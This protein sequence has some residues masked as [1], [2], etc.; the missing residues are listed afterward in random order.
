MTHVL[1]L[2]GAGGSAGFWAPAAGLLPQ[3]WT[4][5]LFSWPGLG[6]EAHHPA[7]RG[8]DDLTAL[9]TARMDGPVHLVAQSMGG[10]VAVKAALARP[11]MVRSLALTGTSGGLDVAALGG[12]DWRDGYRREYPNAAGWIMEAREDL[13]GRIPEIGAPALLLWGD[14]DTIS[15]VAVGERLA[16]L[17]PRATL[18]VIA[19]GDHGFPAA[20]AARIAPL[21]RDHIDAAERLSRA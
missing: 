20:H 6:D 18:R 11:E 14:A 3:G 16:S 8:L 4:R 7:V 17:L 1:F 2:P 10:M 5:H 21:I 12:A 15:P 9:V 13:S 19:G